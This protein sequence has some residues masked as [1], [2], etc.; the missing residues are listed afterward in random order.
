M[1]L[2]MAGFIP[3]GMP[4]LL[5]ILL[6][7]LLLFGAAKIPQL[8]KGLGQGISEFKKGVKE[9]GEPEAEEKKKEEK[10]PEESKSK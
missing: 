10:P 8:M 2:H 9:G 3:I 7:V 4:E 5:V 6:V 1:N